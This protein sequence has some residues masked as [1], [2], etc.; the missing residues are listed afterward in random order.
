MMLGEGHILE[1]LDSVRELT[2]ARWVASV[3]VAR[4]L[5]CP[6]PQEV[7]LEENTVELFDVEG[8]PFRASLQSKVL[9]DE[10]ARIK[11]TFQAPMSD[12]KPHRLR[13]TYPRIRTQ[14]DLEIVFRNV[15]L[16]VAKPDE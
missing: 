16:P 15:P 10:G 13:L 6:D 14:R 4:D 8:R 1:R 7:L 5:V 12:A 11:I 9:T 2:G 3:L